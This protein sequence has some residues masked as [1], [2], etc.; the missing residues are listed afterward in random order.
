MRGAIRQRSGALL[1]A[2]TEHGKD[3]ATVLASQSADSGKTWGEPVS[4]V[5]D[6]DRTTDLGDGAFLD[7]KR[8]GLL[9]VCRH[10]HH[11]QKSYAIEVYQSI[12]SGKS[13]QQHSRV[14]AN[15]QGLW[16]PFLF[17]TP[18]GRLLCVYD[19]E[20]TPF[21]RGFVG[22]QWLMGRFWD[23]KTKT[24]GEPVVV[25]RAEDKKLS[26]DGMG[27]VV[28]VGKRLICALE[29]V[30]TEPPHPGVI[31]IVTSDDDGQTWAPRRLLFQAPQ[32]P[33]MALSPFLAKRTD[34]TL[35]CIFGTDEAQTT[36][37]KS[38]TPAPKL[39]LDIKLSLS[40]DGGASWSAPE[41]L[42]VGGHRNYLP[43]LIALPK[44]KLYAHWLNF[45]EDALQ[46]TIL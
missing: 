43:G 38:G 34:G 11:A 10:N 26:R 3:G 33:H 24:W 31:R 15:S 9:Y 41:T 14:I 8:H 6:P 27:T 5:R 46:G 1:G 35:I 12:D 32:R 23:A 21:L 20:N 2:R 19:D 18:G 16:A 25:S 37:D 30:D 4:I 36:P 39:H 45:A 7:S 40:H 28:S 22:H 42:F 13:W 44:N 29:S 17:D